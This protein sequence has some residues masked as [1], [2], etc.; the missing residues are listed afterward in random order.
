MNSEI[1]HLGEHWHCPIWG[2]LL[3]GKACTPETRTLN[4]E[5]MVALQK[6]LGEQQSLRQGLDWCHTSRSYLSMAS[7]LEALTVPIASFRISLLRTECRPLEKLLD[8]QLLHLS[9][10]TEKV[11]ALTPAWKG[12]PGAHVLGRLQWLALHSLEEDRR[13]SHIYSWCLLP[14]DPRCVCR[15]PGSHSEHDA[16]PEAVAAAS[17]AGSERIL[18]APFLGLIAS[19]SCCRRVVYIGCFVGGMWFVSVPLLESFQALCPFMINYVLS[20]VSKGAFRHT[21]GTRS[22]RGVVI[23]KV[24]KCSITCNQKWIS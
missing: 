20:S 13:T 12:S 14:G 10:V 7:N 15:L 23:I 17:I 6:D 24:L 1:F 8:L 11:E 16:T 2:A 3:K 19:A 9:T 4:H 21:P 18:W 5:V 22:E